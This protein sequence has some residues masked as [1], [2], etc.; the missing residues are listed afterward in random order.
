MR[1]YVA[2]KLSPLC[3]CKGLRL[4]PPK[5]LLLFRLYSTKSLY[6]APKS[7]DQIAE[8]MANRAKHTR[9]GPKFQSIT[10]NFESTSISEELEKPVYAGDL[11]LVGLE[12]HMVLKTP[13]SPTD[14]FLLTNQVGFVKE[15][16]LDQLDARLVSIVPSNMLSEASFSIFASDD[17]I[18]APLQVAND[19]GR[20]KS[21]SSSLEKPSARVVSWWVHRLVSMPLRKIYEEANSKANKILPA[22]LNEVR[23][24]QLADSPNIISLLDFVEKVAGKPLGTASVVDY[25]ATKVCLD[26]NSLE[27][28]SLVQ[29]SYSSSDALL[30][31]SRSA[32]KRIENAM[33]GDDPDKLFL[34]EYAQGNLPSGSSESRAIEFMRKLYPDIEYLDS[35]LS[36]ELL[37][38]ER[39]G[40]YGSSWYSW[41][42]AASKNSERQSG[43]LNSVREDQLAS[44]RTV[45]DQPVYC[46]DSPDAEEV[47]DG[48]SLKQI[49]SDFYRIGVHIANPSA[50]LS[51]KKALPSILPLTSSV[52]LSG[53]STLPMLPDEFVKKSNLLQSYGPRPTLTLFAD[54]N[55]KSGEIKN[56]EVKPLTV[57]RLHNVDAS[58]VSR[59]DETYKPFYKIA[60]KLL[61]KR[62]G[63]GGFAFKTYVEDSTNTVMS[64]STRP[65]GEVIVTE[66]MNLANFLTAKYCIDNNIPILF[67]VQSVQASSSALRTK[68][69]DHREKTNGLLGLPWQPLAQRAL[70][71]VHPKK[72]T[73]IGV[74]VATRFTSPLRRLDDLITHT[75][76][77]AHLLNMPYPFALRDLEELC[78]WMQLSQQLISQI[79]KNDAKYDRYSDLRNGQEVEGIVSRLQANVRI[80]SERSTL[81]YLPFSK[82]TVEYRGMT[83]L[84]LEGRYT[85][86]VEDV[87][88]ASRFA[89]VTLKT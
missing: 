88:P 68:F 33:I 82:I 31:I 43:I 34:I 54:F 27:F 44:L 32:E 39:G 14:N 9:R 40:L 1:A 50:I 26:H 57:L 79:S 73:G 84:E 16:R 25:Y 18:G 56:I 63:N 10:P 78:R 4:L 67:R 19:N 36:A 42:F 37:K 41:M 51:L 75:Q 21:G 17:T 64:A 89:S 6:N 53:R 35:G 52:Y 8:E 38:L 85:F 59:E 81:I 48:I 69:E 87:V 74:D 55:L 86:I 70:T 30:I 2:L 24:L 12:P 72:H 66:F 15:F 5:K 28:K 77:A 65:D 71:T 58:T 7:F 76:I 22:V 47:D 3:F 80:P 49:D 29:A 11:V 46:I 20:S 62:F 60:Y 61:Q 45:F 23:N 13:D 83:P